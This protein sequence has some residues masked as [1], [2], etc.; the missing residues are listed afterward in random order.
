[1]VQT[2]TDDLP[3]MDIKIARLKG[4]KVNSLADP[5]CLERGPVDC[6]IGGDCFADVLLS[7]PDIIVPGKPSL[8]RTIW[9][10]VLFVALPEDLPSSAD[11]KHNSVRALSVVNAVDAFEESLD[12]IVRAFWEIEQLP[13]KRF[14]SPD[15]ELAEKIFV[16]T[17]T[18]DSSGRYC[19]TLPFVPGLPLPQS[20]R[21]RAFQS[22][23]AMEARVEKIPLVRDKY[24]AFMDEYRTLDHMREVKVS[25]P[26]VIPH[27]AV[28]KNQDIDGKV[29]VVFAACCPDVTG[30]TFLY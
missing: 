24:R 1:M 8:L 20:N 9:G 2:I 26:Y 16:E 18:R 19:V 14:A 27:H 25:S 10:D 4:I 23:L 21:A 12:R 5:A 13:V 7:G 17:T 29:R 28:F 30:L 11:W 22:F 15:E 3:A 6:L